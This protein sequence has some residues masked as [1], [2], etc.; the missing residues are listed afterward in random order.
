M[1]LESRIIPDYE[2]TSTIEAT[3][4]PYAIVEE[5]I[6]SRECKEVNSYKSADDF[7]RESRKVHE[8]I[9]SLSDMGPELLLK[10]LEEEHSKLF[11]SVDKIGV[12]EAMKTQAKSLENI[13]GR[14]ETV[15]KQIEIPIEQPRRMSRALSIKPESDRDKLMWNVLVNDSTIGVSGSKFYTHNKTGRKF[16]YDEITGGR[17]LE[18]SKISIGPAILHI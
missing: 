4:I 15:L 18:E 6:D 8:L 14:R 16:I 5:I 9:T 3:V 2:S 13:R 11:A 17:F 10:K 1:L 12:F 7:T